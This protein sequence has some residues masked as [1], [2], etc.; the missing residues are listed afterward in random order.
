ME[1]LMSTSINEYIKE[2]DL[3]RA[4][5]IIGVLIVHATALTVVTLNPFSTL[6]G[7]YDFLNIVFKYGTPTFIF[8]SGFILFHTYINKPLNATLVK[9]FYR[10][11]LAYIV[12]P[13]LLFSI[14]YVSM[15]SYFYYGFGEWTD[16]LSDLLVRIFTGNAHAHLYFVIISIQFYVLSPLLLKVLQSSRWI[17]R[18]TYWLGFAIQ[19]AFILLNK[20]I[21]HVPEKGSWAFSYFSFFLLGAYVGTHYSSLREKVLRI[22]TISLPIL[23]LILTWISSFTAHFGLIHANR[24][25]HISWNSLWYELAWNLHTASTAL[26]IFYVAH[27]LSYRLPNRLSNL[28][29]RLGRASFG[30][31][32]VHPLL[33]IAY[34]ALVRIANPLWY[35]PSILFKGLFILVGSY[36]MVWIGSK[37]LQ[38]VAPFV[39]GQGITSRR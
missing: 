7:L 37:L 23:L 31:Y 9:R 16:W 5:A 17:I 1:Y 11:R 25:Y 21:I 20:Y 19:W 34:E 36:I 30:I 8:L 33:L 26:L 14:V 18:N 13:Y 32:L 22:H 10:R 39:F 4:M 35:H 15:K 12:L 29:S 38:G 28:L 27:R 3:V 24:V 6:Y 2:V